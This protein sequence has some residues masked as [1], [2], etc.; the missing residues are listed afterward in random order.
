MYSS[1]SVRSRE[2]G[3]GE[4]RGNKGVEEEEDKKGVRM[5]RDEREGRVGGKKRKLMGITGS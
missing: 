3:G 1:S 2:V 4:K 5:W